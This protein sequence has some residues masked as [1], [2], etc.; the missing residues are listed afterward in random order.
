[1]TQNKYR[2]LR[3]GIGAALAAFGALMSFSVGWQLMGKSMHLNSDF[4]G[5]IAFVVG[6]FVFGHATCSKAS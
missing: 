2:A 3:G 5:F 4:V 6:S 1:M